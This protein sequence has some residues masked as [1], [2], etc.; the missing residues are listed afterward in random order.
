MFKF[1]VWPDVALALDEVHVL[2]SRTP[3]V[4]LVAHTETELTERAS[5]HSFKLLLKQRSV[6][7]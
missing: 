4:S 5:L 6:A 2:V 7:M 1:G 3:A